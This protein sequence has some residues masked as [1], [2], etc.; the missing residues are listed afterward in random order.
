MRAV[1]LLGADSPELLPGLSLVGGESPFHRH[2][3]KALP[4]CDWRALAVP[5]HADESFALH[6]GDAGDPAV[7]AAAARAR[8]GGTYRVLRAEGVLL[9][10]IPVLERP[11]PRNIACAAVDP[12]SFALVEGRPTARFPEVAGWSI[13]DTALRAVAEQRARLGR[14]EPTTNSRAA[15][16]T[17][18]TAA[19]AALLHESLDHEPTVP[20]TLSATANLL[21]ER[22]TTA[23]TV[24]DDALRSLRDGAVPPPSTRKALHKLVTSLPAY[25][26]P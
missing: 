15:L 19:R 20:L 24:A 10:P 6:P 22:S 16:I 23:R 17:L 9:F 14:I 11:L 18:L 13:G 3:E 2:P 25:Q 26:A 1:Q 7:L 5:T 12:V 21:A 8:R 4:L